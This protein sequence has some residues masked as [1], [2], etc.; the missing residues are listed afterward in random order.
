MLNLEPLELRRLRFDLVMYHKILHGL[1]SID[2]SSHFT[3]Y[4]PPIQYRSGSP[5][6]VKPDKGN[7]N[8]KHS[9]FN[10]AADCRNNLP[11][12]LRICDSLSQ[13]KR[14]LNNTDLSAYLTCI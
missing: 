8:L 12:T 4:Y 10:R 7:N 11:H 14:C 2:I 6:L 5:K 13:V 3:Y 1:M 9:F